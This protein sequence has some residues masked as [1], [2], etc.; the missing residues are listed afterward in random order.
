MDRRNL[1][2]N[3][4][5]QIRSVDSGLQ[6][7]FM[8]FVRYK[9]LLTFTRMT[10]AEETFTAAGQSLKGREQSQMFANRVLR[11]AGRY[12]VVFLKIVRSLS[13][14][15]K[16]HEKALGHKALNPLIHPKGAGP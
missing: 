16:C 4:R 15:G 13:S 7:I 11:L 2:N 14:P 1:H 12:F 10:I 9:H 8:I 5:R 6:I 3:Y